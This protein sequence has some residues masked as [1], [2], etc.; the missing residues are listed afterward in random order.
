MNT[1]RTAQVLVMAP[2]TESAELGVIL[3]TNEV[4]A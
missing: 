2:D 4:T 1:V 3:L